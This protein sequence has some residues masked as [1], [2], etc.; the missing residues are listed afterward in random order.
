MNRYLLSCVAAML[1][2]SACQPRAPGDSDQPAPAHDAAAA[3]AKEPSQARA[4]DARSDSM[5][6]DSTPFVDRVWQVKESSTVEPGTTYVFL[7]NG[8]L[9]IDS[10]H[11]TPSQGQWRFEGGAL[12]MVEEGMPYPTDILALDGH[13]MRIRS[14]NP[15]EPVDIL[16]VAVPGAT[17]PESGRK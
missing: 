2:L 11:G 7:G 17:L 13:S 14:H 10:P 3:A 4:S 12:T 16:L 6:F 15:G 9:V 8:T 1:T 5:Q